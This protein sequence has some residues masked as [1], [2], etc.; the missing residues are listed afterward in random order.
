MM[1]RS[2]LILRPVLFGAPGLRPPQAVATR[3]GA[4]IAAVRIVAG[5]GFPKGDAP[6]L[7]DT[8]MRLAAFRR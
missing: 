8:E 2:T 1:P 5:Y 7:A 4:A 6:L 3:F